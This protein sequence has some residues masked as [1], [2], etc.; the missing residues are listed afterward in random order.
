MKFQAQRGT[1]DVLP[2]DAPKWRFVE[3]TWR[4][5]CGLYGYEEIRTPIFEDFEL[6]ARTSGETSDIVSKEMYDFTDKGG[7]HIALRPEGTAPVVRAYLEH[8]LASA[9][10]PVKLFY[11][12]PMFRYGRPQKGRMRQLHQ[13][14]LECLGPATPEADAE[15][16]EVTVRFYEA[17]GL[18]GLTVLVNSIGRQ[19]ARARFGEAV[20]RQLAG[21]L[22]D[23]PPEARERA[24]KNP[25]RLLDSKDPD[26]KAALEGAPTIGEF[27]EPESRE[28]FDRLCG[29]LDEAGIRYRLDPGIVRG[30]DYYT[31]TVF[32]VQSDALGAQSS[33]CGGGRYDG[34]VAELGGPSTPAVGVGIGIE[35]A[36]I[37]MEAAEAWPTSG[38]VGA[39]LVAATD[40]AR[41]PLRSLAREL[42]S[43]GV[44]CLADLDGRGLKAQF[45]Q[46]DRSGACWALILGEDEMAGGTVTVKNLESGQQESLPRAEAVARVVG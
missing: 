31:D 35:R 7:R 16:I 8:S 14:G 45:K 27:L 34:L 26:V 44:S 33:L 43:A 30:L 38:R 32:E 42:R 20:L 10:G 11:I 39:Y 17:I 2:V 4:R 41:V 21:W 29:L 3:E 9:G 19:E 22:A 24:E 28:H 46:A 25:M 15:V 13:T 18:E 23:Q 6:F 36:L 12:G 1:H 37:A 5:V 40:S